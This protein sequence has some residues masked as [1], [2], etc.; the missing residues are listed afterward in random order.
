M[1]EFGTNL[2]AVIVVEVDGT[3]GLVERSYLLSERSI[4]PG[5]SYRVLRVSHEDA[6]ATLA[7]LDRRPHDLPRGGL[8]ANRPHAPSTLNDITN[9]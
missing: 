6:A 8:V 5:L 9:A 7:D 1:C 4:K 2:R 3:G